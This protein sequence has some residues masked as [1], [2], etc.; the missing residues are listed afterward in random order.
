M[1]HASSLRVIGQALEVA[2]V[3]A[4]ELE[5]HGQYYV[6]WSDSLANPDKWI[7]DWELTGDCYAAG[8]RQDNANC[9]LCFSRSDI[10]RLD[11]RPVNVCGARH[12]PI[13][14]ATSLL[15]CCVPWANTWTGK[16]L[17]R[18]VFPETRRTQEFQS[19]LPTTYV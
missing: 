10:I 4:F 15:N 9:S 1:V 19:Y 5:K 2:D 14:K 3:R 16:Q 6:V 12:H 17:V 13:S 8:A 7:S 11:I 18:F